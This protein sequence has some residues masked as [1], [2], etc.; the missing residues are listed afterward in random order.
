MKKTAA[1]YKVLFCTL[2]SFVNQLCLHQTVTV[3]MLLW[4]FL[5]HHLPFPLSTQQWRNHRTLKVKHQF[6]HLQMGTTQKLGRIIVMRMKKLLEMRHQG[7]RFG[8]GICM[9]SALTLFKLFSSLWFFLS[10][11]VSYSTFQWTLFRTGSRTTKVWSVQK[12]KLTC[13]YTHP[14]S[15]L[16]KSYY[17]FTP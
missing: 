16:P 6:L 13:K 9:S 7:L 10:L 2:E 1:L 3:P 14:F 17:V 15:F 11:L 4:P 8:D 5:K 12:R